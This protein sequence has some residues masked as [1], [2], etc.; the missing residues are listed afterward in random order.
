[1]RFLKFVTDWAGCDDPSGSGRT[2][3][4][5]CRLFAFGVL[6]T[7]AWAVHG[8]LVGFDFLYLD[9]DIYV[10][11]NPHV[12]HG[13]SLD[14]IR[15][16]FDFESYEG[17]HWHPLAWISHMVDCQLFG[18]NA[19]MHHLSNLIIHWQSGILLFL[20]LRGATGSYRKSLLVAALFLV[21]PLNVESVAWIAERKTLLSTLFGFITIWSWLRYCR[22]LRLRYFALALLAF[23]FSLLSKPMLIT[24]PFVLILLDIWPGRRMGSSS[25]L[26]KTR[27]PQDVISFRRLVTEKLPF[28]AVSVT[29]LVIFL[30]TVPLKN[31]SVHAEVGL[32]LRLANAVVAYVRYIF[33]GLVPTN[34]A[35][36][37]PF[38]TKMLP[39]WQVGGALLFLGTATVGAVLTR[40]R[41]PAVFVGWVFFLG[42]LVPALGLVQTGVWPA[43]ADRF[44]YVPFVGLLI[45]A[46][47]G[48]SHLWDRLSYN[49]A[50]LPVIS[51][52]AVLAMGTLAWIQNQYWRN[53]DSLMSRTLEVTGENVLAHD[54]LGRAYVNAGRF[55]LAVEQYEQSARLTPWRA[56]SLHNLGLT[57]I[58]LG[59]VAEGIPYL[60]R[61]LEMEPEH[62]DARFNLAAALMSTGRL[63]LAKT[64]LEKLIELHPGHADAYVNLAILAE[65]QGNLQEALRQYENAVKVAPNHAK[66]HLFLGMLYVRLGDNA[67]AKQHLQRS[68]D[69]HPND[70]DAA[71]ALSQINQIV[72]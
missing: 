44:V 42:T 41:V 71:R 28:F 30:H 5:S 17:T 60:Q 67:T 52:G 54:V 27:P 45:A 56:S 16:A 47:W 18:L 32:A 12:R 7:L 23:V 2:A 61:A 66:A 68:V 69:I 48:L 20:I 64:H 62:L 53:T 51:V 25:P 58:T 8:S 55:D 63:R 65:Q 49:S 24:L 43:L 36:F 40:R 29:F 1:M 6:G 31:T 46:V 13:L 11:H 10:F 70:P 72:R 38:P 9:D 39:L 34:L 15:W 33:M 22:G 21:H 26:A 37:Y 57:L 50:V 19:G 4:W 14:A 3:E 59:R 35:V